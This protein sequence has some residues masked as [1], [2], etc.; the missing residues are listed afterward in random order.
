STA[1]SSSWSAQA[2]IGTGLL[3]SLWASGDASGSM[4]GASTTTTA[5]SSSWSLGNRS[6]AA[7]M[8]QN[9]NDRTEQHSTSV[10]NR[11]ATAVREVSQSEHEQVST[12][13][14]AN[15]NH[16]HALTVQY[17]E[18]VQIYRVTVQLNR[19]D[20]ALFLPFALLD[21][22]T[23][24]GPDLVARFRGELLAGALTPRAAD[25]LL[26]GRGRIELHSAVRVPRA[27]TVADVAL[28]PASAM[29]RTA[30]RRAGDDPSGPVDPP[31]D[32][33]VVP[34]VG[35]PVRP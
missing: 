28:A 19:F 7:S 26:D 34:P 17:Y 5:S 33:P 35:D 29:V 14:V 20:R 16:M 9:I 18:V 6:V 25:L 11:R 31:V 12:R 21:F 1:D 3:T 32:P 15:Y 4:Q 23:A 10:R 24:S 2:T 8:S 27:I 22:S 13:I 30:M